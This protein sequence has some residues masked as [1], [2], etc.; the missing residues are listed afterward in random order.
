MF[1]ALCMSDSLRVG[2]MIGRPAFL[3]LPLEI[4]V[5]PVQE[6]TEKHSSPSWHERQ[7][8]IQKPQKDQIHKNRAEIP[9]SAHR[10][11]K[12]AFHRKWI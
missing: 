9:V 12:L 4:M 11:Y 5:P 7:A 8:L 6:V 2:W 3:P 10:T 1:D